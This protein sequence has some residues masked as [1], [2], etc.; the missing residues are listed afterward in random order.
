MHTWIDTDSDGNEATWTAEGDMLLVGDAQ[1]LEGGGAAAREIIRLVEHNN[2]LMD[3]VANCKRVVELMDEESLSLRRD[4][5][6]AA[7]RLRVYNPPP[8]DIIRVCELLE[9]RGLAR[10]AVGGRTRASQGVLVPI[11]GLYHEM[12]IEAALAHL[13]TRPSREKP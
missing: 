3:Q 10:E 8:P 2:N 11:D 12:T 4:M 5:R 7:T 6:E 1:I 9:R 13:Q